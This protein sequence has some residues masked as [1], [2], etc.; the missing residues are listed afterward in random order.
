LVRRLKTGIRGID[1]LPPRTL[2]IALVVLAGL[3]LVAI[4]LAFS[5]SRSAQNGDQQRTAVSTTVLDLCGQKDAL[6]AQLHARGACD[7]AIAADRVPSATQ[8]GQ[9][10]AEII[11]LIAAYLR[12][13]PQANGSN[14]A[15]IVEAARQVLAAN[16]DLYRGPA[17]PGPTDDQVASAAAAY[18][19]AH[20][21]DFKGSDG[22]PGTNGRGVQSGPRF[23]RNSA[24][25]CE[26]VT[27]YTDGTSDTAPAGDSACP[28][29]SSGPAPTTDLPAP[30]DGTGQPPA[31]PTSEPP[32]AST[33]P[34][35][36]PPASEDPG[37]L[38]GLLG[39]G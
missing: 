23:E 25:D 34:P 30:P 39:G 37:L 11:A 32:S 33:A 21:A 8:T 3:A 13:H 18:I 6:S 35:E 16:P 1:H 4:Y 31:P 38:G 27:T 12:D 20:L 28:G 26:S 17:G 24:G 19:A 15:A 10:D 14:P 29:G 7:V 2:T 22:A 36:Q 5:A 9:T